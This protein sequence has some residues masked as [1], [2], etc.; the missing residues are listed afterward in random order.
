MILRAICTPA[1]LTATLLSAA[2]ILSP[3]A[4]AEL[5][6]RECINR[7][8]QSGVG[9]QLPADGQWYSIGFL[10]F[11]NNEASDLVV[12]SS[13][14]LHEDTAPGLE[15]E[16]QMTLDGQPA[17]WWVRRS[18]LGVPDT[19]VFRTLIT[20][21]G[22][23]EHA[24]GIR[25]RNLSAQPALYS[26]FWI[27]PLLVPSGEVD[28][29]SLESSPASVSDQWSPILAGTLNPGAQKHVFAIGYVEVSSGVG[30]GAIEFRLLR[31][32]Q[33]VREGTLGKPSYYRDGIQFSFIDKDVGAGSRSYSVELRCTGT[34][35]IT[36]GP[37]SLGLITFP[38][39]TVLEATSE[40]ASLPADES[41]HLIASS[42]WTFLR[43]MSIGPYGGEGFGGTEFTLQG[44]Y[45]LEGLYR[46]GL[47]YFTSGL[48][49]EVGTD[50]IHGTAGA[51]SYSA[52]ASDWER[53]GLWGDVPL[54]MDTAG[55][56]LCASASS[57]QVLD[58]IT[59]VAVVPDTEGFVAP[60]VCTADPSLC[61]SEFPR[62]TV[63]ACY[64]SGALSEVAVGGTECNIIPYDPAA[65]SHGPIFANGFETGGLSPWSTT[66]P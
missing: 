56:G 21:V 40:S 16:Y 23:A 37:R 5:D 35:Q 54:R 29:L 36:A 55:I 4:G 62:C 64:A 30:A 12:V 15:I 27:T 8:S 19:H 47:R 1:L 10:E 41:W 38:P 57:L 59:Q 17:G 66:E 44:S 2:A 58:A 3:P 63:Y 32:G 7:P 51:S 22:V 24:L 9:W 53:L 65:F 39:V 48:E 49:F 14:G 61:C 25:A 42:P 31:D 52:L 60:Y 13:V 45:A 46:H 33:V 18:P 6:V 28:A 34:L 20:G 50:H 26:F 11:N 43:S